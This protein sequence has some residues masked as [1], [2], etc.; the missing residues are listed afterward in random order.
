MVKFYCIIQY[1]KVELCQEEIK[2]KT[3][4]IFDF[5]LKV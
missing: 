2:I 4:K 5:I 3:L 1:N